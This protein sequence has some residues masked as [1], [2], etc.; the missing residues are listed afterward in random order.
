MNRLE[1][2][3]E[4]RG[5]IHTVDMV[6]LHRVLDPQHR[7]ANLISHTISDVGYLLKRVELLQEYYEAAELLRQYE[8]GDDFN[9]RLPRVEAAAAA[10]EKE[11]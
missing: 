5:E 7:Q 9:R 2:I 6:L 11:E 4:R 10:I 3:K 1:K 8:P